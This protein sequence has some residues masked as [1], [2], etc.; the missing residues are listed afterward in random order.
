MGFGF[1]DLFW[2]FLFLSSLQPIWQRRQI[3]FRRVRAIQEFERGRNS[4]V[5]LL[6]H[7]QESI[8]LLGIP[9]SRYIT[10]EDSEQVLR[11]IRLTPPDV[12]IDL[13]LHTPGGLVLATEQI[14]RALIRHPA[15]VTVYVPH[16]A[17]SGGTMLAL[18]SDEIVM[19]ANAVLGPVDP[20]L[21][22]FPA[23]SILKVVEEKPISEIDDQTLIMADLSRKAIAQ[24]QRFVRTLLKDNIPQQKIKPENI[25]NIIE[26]LTTGRVTHDY[27]ITV[28]EA[29]EM[30]L[31]ITVGL[32]R[33]IYDLMEFYPQPQGGRPS[34]QYIPMPYGDRRPVLPTPKGRPLEPSEP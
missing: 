15:K 9:I 33:S 16:Y 12:P 2:V 21:G 1:F 25:E 18:A 20:Q 29:S 10:I 5:I 13:I 26:A 7:R 34:V 32:P 23:A 30:G 6:I 24:V 3:E 28:E 4:R 11:A 22:N 14:A 27:P 17:M 8:S 19:D 31:P